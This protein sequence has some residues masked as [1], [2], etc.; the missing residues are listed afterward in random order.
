MWE[1]C[2]NVKFCFTSVF[3]LVVPQKRLISLSFTISGL[4]RGIRV[5][6]QSLSA[7]RPGDQNKSMIAVY[8]HPLHTLTEGGDGF[9]NRC[10]DWS[11]K[12]LQLSLTNTYLN[13]DST[14][15][16]TWACS[17]SFC[18][19]RIQAKDPDKSDLPDLALPLSSLDQ[20]LLLLLLDNL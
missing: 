1:G 9:N 19:S 6:P 14:K 13:L 10:F 18:C 2:G 4:M 8:F 12:W 7:L 20:I 11:Q 15:L 16:E 17:R 5:H 3:E